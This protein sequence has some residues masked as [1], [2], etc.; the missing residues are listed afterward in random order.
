[1]SKDMMYIPKFCFSVPFVIEGQRKTSKLDIPHW[2][3]KVST[4]AGNVDKGRTH[5]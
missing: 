3:S 5:V 2:S 1:M 4:A